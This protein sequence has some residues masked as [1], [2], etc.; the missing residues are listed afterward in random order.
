[1]YSKI[2]KYIYLSN[3]SNQSTEIIQMNE[4]SKEELE[5]EEIDIEWEYA[6]SEIGDINIQGE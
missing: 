6:P 1:M 5:L 2:I 3:Q 4:E